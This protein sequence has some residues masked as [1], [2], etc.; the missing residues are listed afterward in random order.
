V[1]EVALVRFIDGGGRPSNAELLARVEQLETAL[2]GASASGKSA[3]DS[4]SKNTEADA[5]VG[6]KKTPSPKLPEPAAPAPGF[7]GGVGAAPENESVNLNSSDRYGIEQIRKWWPDMMQEIKRVN[8]AAYT[9]LSLVWPAET[10]DNCLV[11]GVPAGDIFSMQMATDEPIRELLV[12]TLGAFTRD[13]WTVRC[14]Y[15]DAPPPG[16]DAR[17]ASLEPEEAISLFRGQEV[18]PP[19]DLDKN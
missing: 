7:A 6:Q 3:A 17:Q 16:W 15:Y 8:P 12:R 9:Y 14:S 10:K 4:A 13:D 11:L 18:T 5:A 19:G 2:I 1:L